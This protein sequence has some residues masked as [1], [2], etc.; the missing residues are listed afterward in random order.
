MNLCNRSIIVLEKLRNGSL[1]ERCGAPMCG[2]VVLRLHKRPVGIVEDF[3][4]RG[5]GLQSFN[6]RYSCNA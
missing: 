1:E 3:L 6:L 5:F 4:V 2:L